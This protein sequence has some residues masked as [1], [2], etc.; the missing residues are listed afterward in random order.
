[1]KK[2]ILDYLTKLFLLEE[3]AVTD[4]GETIDVCILEDA[5]TAVED[6]EEWLEEKCKETDIDIYRYY[7]F[8]D[9]TVCVWDIS[10]DD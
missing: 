2:Q 1:M 6:F 5:T 4:K 10:F 3:V 9:V 7:H 8:D